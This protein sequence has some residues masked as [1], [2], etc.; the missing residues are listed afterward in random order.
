MC[1][2]TRC[3]IGS[4]YKE[5][6][7]HSYAPDESCKKAIV[8]TRSKKCKPGTMRSYGRYLPRQVTDVFW[9]GAD[10]AGASSFPHNKPQN[11]FS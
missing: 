10:R 2:D 7:A 5:Y 8:L 9:A 3:L 4:L 1:P 6:S 11:L